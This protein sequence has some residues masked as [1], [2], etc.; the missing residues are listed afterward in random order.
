MPGRGGNGCAER[1][2][3]AIYLDAPHLERRGLAAKS[4]SEAGRSGGS[5]TRYWQNPK[6][7]IAC[8]HSMITV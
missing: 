8:V 7:Q 5:P 6:Y 2:L 1:S 3:R 4:N